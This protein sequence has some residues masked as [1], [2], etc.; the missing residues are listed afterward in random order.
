MDAVQ[1]TS[2]LIAA[3]KVKGT[4]VFNPQGDRIG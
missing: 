1:E 3:D 2:T 4:Y